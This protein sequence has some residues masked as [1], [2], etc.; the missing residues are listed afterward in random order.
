MKRLTT[1]IPLLAI[2]FAASTSYGAILGSFNQQVGLGSPLISL[3]VSVSSPNSFSQPAVFENTQITLA[4]VGQTY[5][6]TSANDPNFSA[7]AATLTNGVNDF[8]YVNSVAG[9]GFSSGGG[10]IGIL[11][12]NR[13]A[14]QLPLGKV[15]LSGNTLSS[16]KMHITSHLGN[17]TYIANFEFHGDPNVTSTVPEPATLSIWGL[18]ALGC[19]VA[20]YRRKRLAA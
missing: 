19:A 2:A 5:T 14:G 15:D 17:G 10:S 18:G 20:A 11:E 12:S 3:Y 8:L 4:S 7:L 1:C 13:F 16:I 9:P 6:A